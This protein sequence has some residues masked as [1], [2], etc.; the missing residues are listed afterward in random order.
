M[1]ELSKELNLDNKDILAICDRLSI[2]VKSHSSTISEAEADQIRAAAETA[3]QPSPSQRPD[4]SHFHLAKMPV[5]REQKQQN[6]EIPRLPVM[7][8]KPEV[9]V[10]SNIDESDQVHTSAKQVL[11]H[12]ALDLDIQEIDKQ[13]ERINT[14]E[15]NKKTKNKDLK[16]KEKHK[17]IDLHDQIQKKFKEE[18]RLSNFGNV[19]ERIKITGFRCHKSTIIDIESPITALCGCNGTGKSTVL[20]L[21][22]VAY[23]SIENVKSYIIPD[24]IEKRRFDPTPFS[25]EAGVEFLFYQ[26]NSKSSVKYKKNTL[27]RRENKW[28]GYKGRPIR[29]VFFIGISSYIPKV[30]KSDNALENIRN[31]DLVKEFL[32]EDRAK[33]WICKILSRSYDS[34]VTKEVLLESSNEKVSCVKQANVIYS[35]FHM[36]FGEARS[37]YLVRTLEDL[38]EKSL[39]LI[40]EPE[41]SLHPSAQFNFGLYLVDLC[42]RK[43]HQLLLTTHSESLLNALPQESRIF[44]KQSEDGVEVIKHLTARQVNSLMTDGYSVAL[45]IFVEDKD[46]KSIAKIILRE[47]LRKEDRLF[48]DCVKIHPIGSCQDVKSVLRALRKSEIIAVGVLDADQNPIPNENILVLPKIN[49]DEVDSA[50]EKQI[51]NCQRVKEYV[52]REYKVNLQEFQTT[53]LKTIDHHEWFKKLSESISIDEISLMTEL[54]RA[55]VSALPESLRSG[56]VNQLKAA[57]Q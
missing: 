26:P 49:E 24:F 47:I 56:L 55:Y 35:E 43:G 14:K 19:L 27:S 41:I 10:E 1:Y 46:D 18:N 21:A 3:R 33:D 36:G 34:V 54:A 40:E 53:K 42:I 57:C 4:R 11:N 50:P 7:A 29:P 37:H 12:N 51:F 25:D 22:A 38:P 48:L 31:I 15:N 2:A 13:G 44:L 30:E 45:N 8:S 39:I 20:H 9:T 28:D 6:L 52:Q 17:R 5:L 32:V 16:Q 23:Q